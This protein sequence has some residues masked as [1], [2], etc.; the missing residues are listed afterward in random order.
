[1]DISRKL[2][3]K[4]RELVCEPSKIQIS[5]ALTDE[6]KVLSGRGYRTLIPRTRRGAPLKWRFQ[7]EAGEAQSLQTFILSETGLDIFIDDYP[8]GD[9]VENP[10][11]NN[12]EKYAANASQDIILLNNAANIVKLNQETITLFNSVASA[13]IELRHNQITSIEHDAI[14]ICENFTPMYY[15]SQ[16]KHNPIFANALVIYRGDSQTGKRADQVKQFINRFSERLPIYYFG[17]FDPEGLNIAKSFNVDGI[18]LP[19]LA[20]FSALHA[21]KLQQL[22]GEDKYFP[23]LKGRTHVEPAL[24]PQA[25]HTHITFMSKHQLGWQQE[26]LLN[27]QVGWELYQ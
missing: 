13:G 14:I 22:A 15:L 12:N 20:T 10:A 24:Y 25:W 2:Y 23:Q 16:L 3:D 19:E 1:M 9:R 27:A 5:N 18:L 21:K 8:T 4:C 6:I 26:H 11:Q 17:D 7:L